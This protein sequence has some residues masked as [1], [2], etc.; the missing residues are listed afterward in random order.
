[1]NQTLLLRLRK[2]AGGINPAKVLRTGMNAMKPTARTVKMTVPPRSPVAMPPHPVPPVA[3]PRPPTPAP[4]P[5]PAPV[6]A[7]TPGPV[8]PAPAARTGRSWKPAAV[9]GGV[10]AGAIALGPTG[11]GAEIGWRTGLAKDPSRD[12]GHYF[13]QA[14]TQ[15]RDFMTKEVEPVRQQYDQAVSRG[16]YAA[17]PALHAQL[18]KLHGRLSRNDF[19]AGV[20]TRSASE[21][22]NRARDAWRNSKQE[23]VPRRASYDLSSVVTPIKKTRSSTIEIT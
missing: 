16:D 22:I 15:R 10:G 4:T 8:A 17:I 23:K 7:P 9:A 1:M 3:A 2:V 14:D 21:N 5:A 20:F 6:P 12:Y 13:Q 11:L 19:G 18:T